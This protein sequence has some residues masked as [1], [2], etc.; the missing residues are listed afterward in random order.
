MSLEKIDLLTLSEEELTALALEC[1]EKKYRGRQL[2]DWLH[3]KRVNSVADMSNLSSSFRE[4]LAS[5][6]YIER[7]T[8]DE[9]QVSVDGTRKLQFMTSDDQ[10]IES[11]LIPDGDKTTM[12]ISSQVGCA[13]GCTF[14]ATAKLGLKRNLR[15]SEIVAQVYQGV[16]ILNEH[17]EGRRLTNIVY[18]GMGEPLHNY[19]NV[20][21]SIELISDQRG[22]DLSSRRITVSS[23][24]LVPAIEKLGNDPRVNPNIAISLN[25]SNDLVRNEIMPVNRKYDI[26]KLLTMLKRYPLANRRNIT[27]EYVLLAGVNDSLEDAKRVVRLLHGVKAKLN[28]IPFNPHPLAPFKRPT[29]EAIDEFQKATRAAGLATYIR[30]PRGDDIAAACGQLANRKKLQVIA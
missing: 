17:D 11:V 12:C 2:W 30:R 19:E 6:T 10:A 5:K 15:A 18:M 21:R 7:L 28:V 20:V 4:L 9:M 23:V 8:L 13:M 1:G 3:I 16:E 24:G 22:L 27:F 25:A 29:E 26:D 14:C